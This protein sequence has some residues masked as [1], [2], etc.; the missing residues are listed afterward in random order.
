MRPDT[1]RKLAGAL[2]LNNLLAEATQRYGQPLSGIYEVDKPDGWF[3]RSGPQK[4]SAISDSESFNLVGLMYA[5]SDENE[6][7][8][9]RFPTD[10]YDEIAAFWHKAARDLSDAVIAEDIRVWARNGGIA[11]P[12]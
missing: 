2:C 12:F 4:K 10:K 9:G 5:A 7:L 8:C 3:Y 11:G 6:T 1:S